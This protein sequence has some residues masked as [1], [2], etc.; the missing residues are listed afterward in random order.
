MSGQPILVGA[1]VDIGPL[2]AAEEAMR[3]NNEEL[4]ARVRQNTAD[5]QASYAKLR[6]TEFAMNRPSDRH[7][8]GS[9]YG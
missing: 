3:R 7:C 5:L 9:N 1:G 8:T 4:E 6:D 2:K